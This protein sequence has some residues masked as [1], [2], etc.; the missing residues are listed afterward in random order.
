MPS[1]KLDFDIEGVDETT[2]VDL[3]KI[4]LGAMLHDQFGAGA[5]GPAS[6]LATISDLTIEEI[7]DEPRPIV[8]TEDRFEA[9][10]ANA[11]FD[12][13]TLVGAGTFRGMDDEPTSAVVFSLIV[14]LARHYVIAI[15]KESGIAPTVSSLAARYGSLLAGLRENLE[16]TIGGVEI[17]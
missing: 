2:V 7:E 8:D 10:L 4:W 5:S 3:M 14:Q 17:R 1:I 6:D 9:W 16:A 13:G 15:G 12:Y 11:T